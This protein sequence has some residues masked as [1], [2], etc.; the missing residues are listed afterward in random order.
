[1]LAFFLE[2]SSVRGDVDEVEKLLAE[3][4]ASAAKD[5]RFWHYKGW[6][7]ANLSEWQEAEKCYRKAL[8][9]HPYAWRSQFE[10]ADV[11][12]K[13]GDLRE[14]ERLSQLSLEGK[15][16]QKTILQLPDVQSVPMDIFKRMQR[17]A[18][19]CGDSPVA[20]RMK[21]RI[22]QYGGG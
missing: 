21:E 5:N 12:R 16:L 2:E 22:K 14:V 11:L 13:S 8:E 7:H 1:L 15:D 18:N 10:L 6:Y 3:V 17:Y 9:L 4:P 19:D 20:T